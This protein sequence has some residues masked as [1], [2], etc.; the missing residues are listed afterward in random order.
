MKLSSL[1]CR[2]E[3]IFYTWCCQIFPQVLPPLLGPTMSISALPLTRSTLWGTNPP[4]KLSANSNFG[5]IYV[6]TNL[7]T[8]PTKEWSHVFC[9][10]QRKEAFPT[11]L[12]NQY[13]QPRKTFIKMRGSNFAFDFNPIVSRY[14]SNPIKRSYKVTDLKIWNVIYAKDEV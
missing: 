14:S 9:R 6:M 8:Y 7:N 3:S 2:H 12:C 4:Y 5:N 11:Y 10:Y 1:T 13:K